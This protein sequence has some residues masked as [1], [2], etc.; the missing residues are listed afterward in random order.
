M[1]RKGKGRRGPGTPSGKGKEVVETVSA[2][3]TSGEGWLPNLKDALKE[4]KLLKV[5]IGYLENVIMQAKTDKD[6]G[7]AMKKVIALLLMSSTAP[8]DKNLTLQW[9]A[10]KGLKCTVRVHAPKHRNKIY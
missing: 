10:S 1:A 9:A 6:K 8:D 4:A 5:E 2:T 7:N 3:S